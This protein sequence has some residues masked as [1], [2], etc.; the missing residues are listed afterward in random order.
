MYRLNSWSEYRKLALVLKPLTVYFV[1]DPHPLRTPPWGLRLI[2]YTGFDGYVFIDYADG[3]ELR[4]TK[5]PIRGNGEDEIPIL[6][7]DIEAFLSSQI[8]PVN[9]SPI[10]FVS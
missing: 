2:F 7:K 8:G 5:T 9:V 6:V 3:S 10:W 1:R 4:K